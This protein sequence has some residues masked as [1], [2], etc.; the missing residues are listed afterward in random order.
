MPRAESL[1]SPDH[2]GAS[3]HPLLV[4]LIAPPRCAG[5]HSD[6]ADRWHR[7]APITMSFPR[8]REPRGGRT[9]PAVLGPRF[10]GDDNRVHQSHE[11]PVAT[12]GIS[13]AV[14]VKL[15]PVAHSTSFSGISCLASSTKFTPLQCIGSTCSRSNFL[16]SAITWR[17]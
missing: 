13:H 14:K 5:R 4:Y 1:D 10:R 16:N 11:S 2:S 3:P 15:L 9:V 12:F 8:N 7:A 17:R 6:D